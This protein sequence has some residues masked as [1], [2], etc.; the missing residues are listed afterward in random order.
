M[1][2]L[3]FVGIAVAIAYWHALGVLTP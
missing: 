1:N 2:V 3:A